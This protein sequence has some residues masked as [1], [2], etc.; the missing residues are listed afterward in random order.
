MK[1]LLKKQIKSKHGKTVY[2]TNENPGR[3]CLVMLHGLTADHRLFDKQVSAFEEDFK[4]IVWDCPCHGESRPYRKFKYD[5][6][7]EELAKILSEEAVKK[8]IFIGQ[9]LGGIIAQRYIEK[10][11]RQALGFISVD[12]IP[13]GS[14]YSETDLFWLSQMKWVNS[15]LPDAMLRNS[16]AKI[17][18]VKK[19]TQNSMKQMLSSYTKN[20]LCYLI[21]MGEAAFIQDNHE[22]KLDCPV[23]LLLGEYD[24]V[25]KV[26]QYNQAWH[27]RS[28]YPLHIIRHAAH[29]SNQDNP[30]E[31]NAL[32]K[33]YVEQWG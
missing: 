20:E 15:W 26:T 10:H 17:C 19:Y 31:V 16:I 29:N 24:K 32:I 3:L 2:W 21:W 11:Q 12:S 18:G 22:L 25:G 28:G 6:A 4:L 8:A 23:A 7:V 30:R 14:Y 33:K 1:T 5:F 13:F 9:S 27:E